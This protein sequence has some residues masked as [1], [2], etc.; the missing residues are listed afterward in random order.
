MGGSGSK[1]PDDSWVKWERAEGS[2][3]GGMGKDKTARIT[4]AMADLQLGIDGL[5]RRLTDVGGG[6]PWSPMGGGDQ[7]TQA[8]G[9]FARTCSVF[10]RKTVLGDRGRR[11]TRLLDDRVLQSIELKF[12]RL[13]AIPRAKRREIEVAFGFAGGGLELTRLDDNTHA[14]EAVHRVPAGPHRATLSIEWPLPG[15][16]DWTGV[17]SDEAPW[18]VRPDQLFEESNASGQTCDEWLGQQ[19]V[20]FDGKGISLK[21]IIQT[22]VNFEA[23]HSIDVGR[24]ATAKGEAAS[25]A[26]KDPAPHILNAVTFCGIRYAHLVVIESALYLYRQLLDVDSI[27]R[28]SGEIYMVTPGVTC[29]P[30]Q[31]QSTR[32]DWAQFRGTMMISFSGASMSIRHRIRAVKN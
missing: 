16:A 17:P 25:R 20:L 23:A 8:L 9:S 24:L 2:L 28:P 10:L 21:K 14:P 15:A 5:R 12:D 32:P 19:V 3:L 27:P 4:D 7:W 26:A 11:E 1:D 22:V 31:A 13:R 18:P 29:S 30:E 6:N